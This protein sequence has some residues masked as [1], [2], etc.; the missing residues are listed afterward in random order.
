M[1]VMTIKYCIIYLVFIK[2]STSLVMKGFQIEC[3]MSLFYLEVQITPKVWQDIMFAFHLQYFV[4]RDSA[5]WVERGKQLA[6]LQQQ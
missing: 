5:E 2:I 6:F 3:G 1:H 4:F